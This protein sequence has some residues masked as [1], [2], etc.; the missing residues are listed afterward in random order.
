MRI[1]E[2]FWYRLRPAHLLLYPASLLF[3]ATVA[4]RR[5]LYRAGWLRSHRVGAPVVV[6]GNLTVGGSGKTPLVVWLARELRSRGRRPGVIT[7]GYSG[8]ERLQAVHADSPPAQAG[9]EAVLLARR[10]GCPVFAGRDRVAAAQ[11]LLR[12]H[13]DCD[14]LLSDDG[15]QHYRLAR[16]V[17]VV[18]VDAARRFGNGLLLP[19]GPLREPRSR[20]GS[21]DAIA[22]NDAGAVDHARTLDHAGT[23][24]DVDTTG[25]G[26][27]PGQGEA[28]N[29]NI[30]PESVSVPVFRMR[31]AGTQLINLLH[32]ERTQA[33]AALAGQAVHAVAGIGH[34]ARFFALLEAAGLRVRPQ[35]FPDHFA[36]GAR[37]LAFAGDAPLLM[38]EKDAVKCAAFARASWWYLPVEAQVDPALAD[39]VLDKLERPHG[40]QAA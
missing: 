22:L 7:R 11:A 28:Q 16:A 14:V 35:P 2:H 39:L 1:V 26:G 5:A 38:T 27:N 32:P 34:P 40:S 10:A 17:E 23:R 9:D 13:P 3:R 4:M 6:I 21:V 33:L 31:L 36:F 18:V 20:L 30:A 24:D 29:G 25:D 12:A 19:A 37:D 8:S 15:L